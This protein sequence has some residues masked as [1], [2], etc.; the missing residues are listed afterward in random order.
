MTSTA[1]ASFDV[2]VGTP[3]ELRFTAQPSGGTAGQALAGQPALVIVDAGGNAVPSA[4]GTV[5]IAITTGT[6]TAGASLSCGA[7]AVDATGSASFAGCAVDQAGG[8]YALTATWTSFTAE[9]LPFAVLRTTAPPLEVAPAGAPVGQTIGSASLAPNPTS[10]V[11]D[12]NTATG[13][14][15]HVFNDL[16]VAGVGHDLVVDRTYNSNDPT[17]GAFGPGFSSIFDLSVTFNAARTEA[18]VR[19]PDGQR[20]VFTGHQGS[21]TPGPGVRADLKCTGNQK[22]CTVTQWDGTTW[23]VT[24]TQLD[25]YSDGNGEGLTFVR[26]S[27]TQMTVKL[28]T[29]DKKVTYDVVVT[30]NATGQITKIKTPANREVSYGYTSGR[31]TSF[32]DARG[33]GLDV[34]LRR[35]PAPDPRHRPDRR[36][37]PHRHL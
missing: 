23:T 12:V 33:Q 2:T 30:L 14:L 36:R 20:V 13:A 24:G 6:G 19:G 3:A 37:P 25:S 21:F 31:L 10:V 22:T 4:G 8:G 16:Q 34:Q 27:P 28:A 11:D 5:A 32:T 26:T 9:S 29:T 1:S 7:A 15:H 17:G 18:T 35:R